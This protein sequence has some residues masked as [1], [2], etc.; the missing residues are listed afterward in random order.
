M[1][2]ILRINYTDI[3]LPDHKDAGK[4]LDI[5]GKGALCDRYGGS[6]YDTITISGELEVELKMLKPSTRI[7]FSP[8]M[9]EK[10]ESFVEKPK[11]PASGLKVLPNKQKCLPFKRD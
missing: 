8:E 2:C 5:L 3:L 10:A 9:E 6:N 11:R 4:I 1:K 7:E